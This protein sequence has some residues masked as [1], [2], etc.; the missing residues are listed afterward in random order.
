M[1]QGCPPG[2]CCPHCPGTAGP[3]DVQ[4]CSGKP[5]W[6]Q[7]RRQEASVAGRGWLR[8]QA[9][10]P[11][12]PSTL[13]SKRAK[14]PGNREGGASPQD[15]RPLTLMAWAGWPGTGWVCAPGCVWLWGPFPVQTHL[16]QCPECGPRGA[17]GSGRV[18]LHCSSPS[19][20]CQGQARADGSS[21]TGQSQSHRKLQ[22]TEAES[23]AA[24]APPS[25]GAAPLL[26]AGLA[27]LAPPRSQGQGQAARLPPGR[28]Q[29]PSW[30]SRS[31]TAM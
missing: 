29:G 12:G 30:R 24:P 18:W 19:C 2:L 11:P 26:G 20:T 7:K 25:P 3:D 4:N 5:I 27:Q 1:T 9:A 28:G 14:W 23:G 8:S 22:E 15:L 6:Y 10:R 17:G 21:H 16:H 13:V 31:S